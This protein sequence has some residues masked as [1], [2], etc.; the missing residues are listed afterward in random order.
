MWSWEGNVH[1]DTDEFIGEELNIFD[2]F[3]IPWSRRRCHELKKRR[4]GVGKGA[5]EA[6][7]VSCSS[8]SGYMFF[9][10]WAPGC[11]SQ[12]EGSQDGAVVRQGVKE[13]WDFISSVGRQERRWKAVEPGGIWKKEEIEWLSS[14]LRPRWMSTP[15]E[16]L[17]SKH[18]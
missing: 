6:A 2:G 18:R 3:Y 14:P 10:V 4:V 12:V 15:I 5:W 17:L 11:L 9:S 7:V 16:K 13:L 1:G 8:H